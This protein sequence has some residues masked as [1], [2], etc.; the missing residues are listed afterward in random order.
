MFRP[1]LLKQEM[2]PL[3]ILFSVF[4][5]SLLINKIFN[6]TI[7]F[8]LS[9]RIA[10]SSMLLFTAIGHFAFTRGMVMML[11]QFVPFKTELVYLTGIIEILAAIGLFIPHLRVITAWLLIVFFI[12]ILPAN[13]YAAMNQIDYQNGTFDG[14]GLSYLWFRIPLQ[15]IFILWTYLAAIKG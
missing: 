2:K 11:P 14:K 8:A 13:I 7:N 12:L 4:I 9:A 6:D 5:I 15:I 3:A 1:L 10:M